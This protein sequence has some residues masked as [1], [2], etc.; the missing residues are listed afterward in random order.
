MT[1]EQMR[2]RGRKL[3]PLPLVSVPR[4]LPVGG[5]V[6]CIGSGPSLT[7]EDVASCQGQGLVVAVNDAI[8]YAPFAVALMASDAEWWAAHRGVPTF[9]G[10]KYCLE[11]RAYGRWSDVQVLRNT[12][13]EGLELDSTGLKTGRNSGAAA[14]NLAVHLGATRILLLGYDCARDRKGREHFFGAHRPGLRNGS[15]YRLFRQMFAKMAA[16]LKAVGVTIVN[17]S[18]R[19]E[20]ECFERQPLEQALAVREVAA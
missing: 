10:L 14:I 5:T 9:S 15:P 6:V 13:H 16:P 20:I 7:L 2:A 17:C 11:P 4:L 12:G 18:R 1:V 3:P 8:Q 19:T